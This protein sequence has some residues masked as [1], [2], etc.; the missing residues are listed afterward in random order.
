MVLLASSIWAF[1]SSLCASASSALACSHNKVI[2]IA[3]C[4]VQIPVGKQEAESDSMALP[5]PD[6]SYEISGTDPSETQYIPSS[7]IGVML[8][9]QNVSYLDYNPPQRRQHWWEIWHSMHFGLPACLGD[10]MDICLPLQEVRL[11]WEVPW[12]TV[13]AGGEQS[14][15]QADSGRWPPCLSADS[16][17][18]EFGPSVHTG[19]FHRLPPAH[20]L[21]WQP[22]PQQPV[23]PTGMRNPPCRQSHVRV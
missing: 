4:L 1:C 10:S 22:S 16:P 17:G 19:C 5:P 8:N 15:P 11:Y 7:S 9:L 2:R 6:T 23:L 13:L 3:A 18:L 21:L 14:V 12:Q 20:A